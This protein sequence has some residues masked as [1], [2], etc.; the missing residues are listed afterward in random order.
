MNKI[1][2]LF[3]IATAFLSVSISSVSAEVFYVENDKGR[4]SMSFPDSWALS[5]N[6]KPDDMLTVWAPGEYDYA[7]CRM[8]V[9]ED[10]RFLVYPVRY[11]G[12]IQRS[13]YS[14]D[15]WFDY[16][17]EHTDPYL[18]YVT[19]VGG[20]GR[21]FASYAEA[22]YTTAVGP[23]MVKQA[24][25]FASLYHD[26]LYVLECSAEIESYPKWHKAFLSVAKS[27]DFTKSISEMKTGYYPHDF[28]GYSP[29]VI[30]G[31]RPFDD[32]YH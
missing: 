14:K 2:K 31:E 30:Y 7:T 21:G 15:F 11:S 23:K 10:R 22:F 5:H 13:A 9:R 16:L 4:F 17:N 20:L 19:D 3:L 29:L 1:L 27:V 32:T 25:M 28:L 6:Q 24:I 12:E 26:K 8:K 18:A